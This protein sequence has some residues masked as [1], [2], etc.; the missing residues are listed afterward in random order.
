MKFDVIIG[1]PPYQV[2]TNENGMQAKP[3]YHLFV[4]QAKKLNPR[5]LTMIIPSRWFSGGM[6][7]ENFRKN[8]LNDSRLRI[9]HDFLD[10][11]DC[12]YGVDIKG[13]VNY[14]LWNRDNK[15]D[16]E[17]NTHQN[18]EII[19][20]SNRPLLEKD[21]DIFI[22]YNNAIPILHKVRQFNE[23][24]IK[25]NVTMDTFKFPTNFKDFQLLL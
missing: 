2:S 16:C 3:I 15:G 25:N 13:G 18:N 4:E 7:L 10:S 1:N 22:R 8:M 19:S 6:G 14:F 23:K 5:Y 12:F 11:K 21:C 9:I 20:F 17:I 24:S